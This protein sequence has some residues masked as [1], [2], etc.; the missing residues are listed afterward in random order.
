MNWPVIDFE[1]C[2]VHCTSLNEYMRETWRPQ[3]G[4]SRNY[5]FLT[6]KPSMHSLVLISLCIKIKAFLALKLSDIIF[7]MLMNCWHFNI[8]EHNLFHALFS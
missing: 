7:I 6:F 1:L 5:F 4:P 8:Y 3:G 2:G